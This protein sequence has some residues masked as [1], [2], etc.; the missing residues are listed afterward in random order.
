VTV[1]LSG[2]GGD[3]LFAGY[4]RHV[5]AERLWRRLRRFPRPVRRAAAQ[6]I[7][8]VPPH[9]ITRAAQSVPFIRSRQAN[10]AHAGSIAHKFSDTLSASGPE[11]M[12]LALT[13]HW[14][15]PAAIVLGATEPPTIITDRGAWPP[16]ESFTERMMFLDLVTYLPDD[17][18]T[19][20]DRASMAVGLEARVPLL[21]HRVVEFAWQLPLSQKLRDGRGKWLLRQVLSRYVPTSLV[22]RPKAGFGIPLAVW[23]RGP[24]RD[25]AEAL[26]DERRLI[27]DGIFAP[28]P[29]RAAWIEHLSGRA[30]RHYHLWDILMFQAW[31]HRPGAHVCG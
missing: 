6:A 7:R 28:A 19:K 2:D 17:I 22:D 24:L 4:N 8:A 31:F 25:W 21:D 13:S 30:D 26:L 10:V 27:E 9:T 11:S 1:A 12:Y 29:V 15:D 3:E 23:L 20:V 14:N 18:L 5:Y 16:L